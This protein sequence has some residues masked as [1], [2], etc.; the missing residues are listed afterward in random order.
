M[1]FGSSS[2]FSGRTCVAK[3]VSKLNLVSI[4][5]GWAMTSDTILKMRNL[6]LTSFFALLLALAGCGAKSDNQSQQAQNLSPD[7]INLE[8]SYGTLSYKGVL[9]SSVEGTNCKYSIKELHLK[10][11]P[12]GS[13]N[14]TTKIPVT[15][16]L[17]A[18]KRPPSGDGS[19]E[20]IFEKAYPATDVLTFTSPNATIT[21]LVFLVPADLVRKA[22]HVGLDVTDGN[23]LWPFDEELKAQPD[24][25]ANTNHN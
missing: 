10:Y 25:T 17:V 20:R 22:D 7:I 6:S 18:T 21:N 12:L 11:H 1:A 15:I 14:S 16:E 4:Y 9:Q 19:W 24:S 3:G 13:I 23:M 2:G 5:K 8:G